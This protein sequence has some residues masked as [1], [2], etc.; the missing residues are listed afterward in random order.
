MGDA[1]EIDRAVADFAQ[2]ENGGLIVTSSAFSSTSFVARRVT[3]I[4][5][6]RVRSPPICG[7]G[8]DQIRACH[9]S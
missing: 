2:T 9:Q 6:S 1:A 5:S 4:V 3:L 8:A 7:A